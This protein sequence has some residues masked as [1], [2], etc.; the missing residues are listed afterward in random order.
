[1]PLADF[2]PVMRALRTE[3]HRR[4]SGIRHEE[5]SALIFTTEPVQQ[6]QFRDYYIQI[7]VTLLPDFAACRLGP[8]Q[9]FQV[10]F[11]IAYRSSSG[12]YDTPC[13]ELARPLSGGVAPV[14]R[15]SPLVRVA[16]R[17][18]QIHLFVPPVFEE[19]TRQSPSH[20]YY[21]HVM[22]AKVYGFAL[23]KDLAYA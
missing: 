4:P 8:P 20:I 5:P 9:R 19:A 14:A 10:F 1:M 15:V 22:I 11:Q 12:D 2:F 16:P 13:F 6:S 21:V 3:L 23:G 7:A 18:Y 17:D